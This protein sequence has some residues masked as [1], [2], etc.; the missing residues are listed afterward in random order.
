MTISQGCVVVSLGLLVA[1]NQ[2]VVVDA[3]VFN[4][5]L[6]TT[7]GGVQTAEVS[8]QPGE[9]KSGFL[10]V[11]WPSVSLPKVSMP[12]IKMPKWPTNTDGSAVSPFTPISAGASKLSAGTR[13]A[14]AGTMGFFSFDKD[15]EAQLPSAASSS[16]TEPSFWERMTGKTP[17]PEGPQTV[18][19][20]MTQP[21]VGQ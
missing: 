9:E 13:K 12:K 14:W 20:F 5:S 6:P 10:P 16:S 4:A 21:R 18:A 7:D 2:T 8:E 15:E 3:Q 11:S 19:E 17:Q 1:L